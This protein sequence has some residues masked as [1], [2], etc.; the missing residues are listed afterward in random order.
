MNET[1]L[2][3]NVKLLGLLIIILIGAM[4]IGTADYE[5]EMMEEQQY[6]ERVETGVHSHF[7]KAIDCQGRF[8]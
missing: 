5:M 6:C 4:F 1:K 7:N 8:K 2:K 3:Q